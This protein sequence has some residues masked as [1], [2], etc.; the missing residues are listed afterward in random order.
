[1]PDFDYD[2][3]EKIAT[4]HRHLHSLC[5]NPEAQ[6]DSQHHDEKIILILRAHP[7]TFF[8]W[9]SLAAVAFFAPIFFNFFLPDFFTIPELLFINIVYYSGLFSYVFVNFL[10]WAYNVGIVTNHRVLDIDYTSVLQKEASGSS[11]DDVTDI[12]GV[13]TGFFRTIFDYG[14]IQV[15]TAGT[16]QNIEFRAVPEPNVVVS[17]ITQVIQ[18]FKNTVVMERRF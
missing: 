6:F 17:I 7:V 1:M 10:L 12:T 4:S 9:L 14:D 5:I 3:P 11:L 16:I 2:D 15:Q 18:D 13:T 8:P